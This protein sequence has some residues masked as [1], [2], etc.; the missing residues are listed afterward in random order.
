MALKIK[1]GTYTGD[2]AA[3]KAI[4]GI[5]FTPKAVFIKGNT[6]T[7]NNAVMKLDSMAAGDSFGWGFNSAAL[8][9]V[10]TSIDADGFT[11]GNDAGIN[12]NT[13]VYY[14]VCIGGT[15]DV[16]SSGSYAGNS[17][18]NR[19]VVTGLTFQPDLVVIKGS[20]N[21]HAVWRCDRHSGDSTS[22][23]TNVAKQANLIQAFN[24]DGFQVGNSAL[25]NTTGNTYYW[26]AIKKTGDVID[27][28][29]YTGNSTDNTNITTA[30]FQPDALWDK[31]NDVQIAAYR[32]SD[33]SGDNSLQVDNGFTLAANKVQ[34]I[35]SN[36]FQIGTDASVNSNLIEYIYVAFKTGTSTSTAAKAALN[37]L[38]MGVG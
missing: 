29:L 28:N 1:V 14:F 31:A 33:M 5:G 25:V 16:I 18:D 9:T 21:N 12:V 23:F 4:T 30:L 3:S 22:Y 32:T 19:D 34:S 24:S 2:G 35:L 10:I 6:L 13:I 11:V 36:G 7:A 15:S 8:T 26:I 38:L 17:T 37:L 20:N 27:T